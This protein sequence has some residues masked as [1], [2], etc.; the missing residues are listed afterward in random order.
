VPGFSKKDA[1]RNSLRDYSV[2]HNERRRQR[3]F[4]VRWK[5]EAKLL[6]S[7]IDSV[8]FWADRKPFSIVSVRATTELTETEEG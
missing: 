4:L 8:R 1:D 3:L 7:N 6:A 2:I 5:E